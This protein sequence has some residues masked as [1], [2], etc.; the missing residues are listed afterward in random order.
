[1]ADQVASQL[2]AH[3]VIGAHACDE[4]GFSPATAARPTQAALASAA[5]FGVGAALPI[6]VVLITTP[7]Q[8]I[9]WMSIASLV[10]WAGLGATSARVGSAPVGKCAWRVAFWG[11]V[12]MAVAAGAGALFGAVA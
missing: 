10:F 7:A 3:D 9:L 6:G 8:L 12:A 4:L 1:L 2:M 11:A 5:S